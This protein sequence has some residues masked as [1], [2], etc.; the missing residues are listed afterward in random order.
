MARLVS[1]RFAISVA[2]KVVGDA[3]TNP[4]GL[5]ELGTSKE[6]SGFCAVGRPGNTSN[7]VPLDPPFAPSPH[8]N[9]PS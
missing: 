3:N 5:V 1:P 4:Y 8:I 9:R 7:P 6:P 2:H